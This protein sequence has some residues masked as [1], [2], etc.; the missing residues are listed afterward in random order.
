[1]IRTNARSGSRSR[2]VFHSTPIEEYDCDGF[3]VMVKRE[4]MCGPE[5]APT[6]SKIRGLF[7]HLQALMESNP[8]LEVIGYVETSISMA[9]W[10]V[11][12]ACH[13]LGLR[14]LIFDP[15][16]L[17]ETELPLL[18]YHRT[19]WERYGAELY[20]Q[21]AGM[22]RVN[23]NIARNVM[24]QD[25]GCRGHL[26]QLGLPLYESVTATAEELKYTIREQMPE[27]GS[28]VVN[29]G[30]G[31]IAAGILQ[32]LSLMAGYEQT[33][34]WGV[35]GR[36]GNIPKKEKQ[37]Y[38]KAEIPPEGSLFADIRPP[39]LLQDPGWEYTQMCKGK[40]PFPCHPYYDLKA[41]DWL[42]H[43]IKTLEQPVLF[44]NI[45]R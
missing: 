26:L 43:N 34:V 45:G 7:P 37:I 42:K 19:Q 39:L 10:G 40:A 41:W 18:R 35:M 28:I 6:F 3:P 15:Q 30:S 16:Y 31:T 12:W 23:W 29:V 20:S 36:S 24:R 13:M 17:P 1:M 9:G 2:G 25:Y 33:P 8:D 32:G 27:V 5:G 38:I 21:P 4:D 11:A 22:A 14:C 44:W